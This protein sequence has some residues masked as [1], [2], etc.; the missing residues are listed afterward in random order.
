MRQ[1]VLY[2]EIKMEKKSVILF[3]GMI[4]LAVVTIN[5]VSA[6]CCEKTTDGNFCQDVEDVNLCDD[7]L[8]I[9]SNTACESTTYCS[10]GTCVDTQNGVCVSSPSATCDSSQGGVY[11][12]QPK[13]NVAQCQIGCCLFD[14]G[15]AGASLVSKTRCDVMGADYSVTPDFRPE[16]TDQFECIA[17]GNPEARGACV[18]ETDE[19]RDCIVETKR[20]CQTSLGDFH[21]GLLC[22]A[23]DLGTICPKTDETTCV[24]GKNEVYYIDSCGNIANVYDASKVNDIDYWTYIK[25]PIKPEEVCGVGSSN[26]DSATCGNCDYLLGSTCGVGN[27]QYGN[28]ICQDLSCTIGNQDTEQD[29]EMIRK[30]QKDND[31]KNPEHGEEWC[32]AP[33][34]NFENPKTGQLSYRLYCYSGEVQYELCSPGR[35]KLCRENI[36]TGSASCVANKWE[37]CLGQDSTES[38]SNAGDC[39]VQ[40]G[41]AQKDENGTAVLI[42]NSTSKEMIKATCTPKYPPSFDFWEEGSKAIGTCPLGNTICEVTYVKTATDR[43]RAANPIKFQE[44]AEQKCQASI[45]QP[46]KWLKNH[47]I[48]IPGECEQKCARDNPS[49]CLQNADRTG[50]LDDDLELKNDWVIGAQGICLAIGDCGV[51]ANY[52]D[53]SGYNPWKNLFLGNYTEESLTN[54]NSYK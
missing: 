3:F 22:S 52:L 17:L 19:G 12:S 28:Y 32:S 8:R 35:D 40:E 49:E 48:S 38:C 23:P 36:I 53:Y 51:K 39:I 9:A 7:G 20:E 18:F 1:E 16:I 46:L 47:F 37:F 15:N 45:E 14:G 50:S 33:I 5:L 6:I 25:D 29:K 34:S 24:I 44:C 41:I 4:F 21:E 31:G 42:E 2:L 13:E 30:F 11:Y 54:A 10:V 43:W 26:A 27:A